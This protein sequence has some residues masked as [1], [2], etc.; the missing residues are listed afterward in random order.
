MKKNEKQ[1]IS[2]I[3]FTKMAIDNPENAV[4]FLETKIKKFKKCKGT[5][6]TVKAL[7]DLLFLSEQTIYKDYS[8]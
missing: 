1:K 5:V 7:S 4:V 3:A 2:R 6:D 8:R